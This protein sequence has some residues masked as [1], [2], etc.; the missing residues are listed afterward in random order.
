MIIKKIEIRNFRGYKKAEINLDSSE[1]YSGIHTFVGLNSGGKT[2][3]SRA[4]VWAFHGE[5]GLTDFVAGK[6]KDKT[7]TN[8]EYINRNVWRENKKNASCGVYIHFIHKGK[9]YSLS[10]VKSNEKIH[11]RQNKADWKGEEFRILHK[12]KEVDGGSDTWMEKNFPL[13]SARF[14]VVDGEDIRKYTMGIDD[15]VERAIHRLVGL[16]FLNETIRLLTG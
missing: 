5:E 11:P 8:L 15:T 14:F 6:K 16:Q 13:S 4:L 2:S 7:V 12:G 9:E 1:N 3:F 10:R